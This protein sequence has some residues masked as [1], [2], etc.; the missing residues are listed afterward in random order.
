MILGAF[1]KLRKATVAS[2]LPVSVCLSVGRPAFRM[3][4]RDPTG[5]ILMKNFVIVFRKSAEKVQG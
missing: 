4:Q 3:E 1:R 5:R 2:S